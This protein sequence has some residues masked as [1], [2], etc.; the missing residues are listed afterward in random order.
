MSE[1]TLKFET[2]L[3]G[4]EVPQQEASQLIE[5][6]IKQFRKCKAPETPSN[7]PTACMLNGRKDREYLALPR[8]QN[9]KCILFYL[10]SAHLLRR[11]SP[12]AAANYFSLRA[13]W[14]DYDICL[15]D[16]SMEWCV[17]VT[18]NNDVSVI[19]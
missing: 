2:P 5:R 1:S 13:P 4:D 9:R 8:F 15:F 6:F 18:H 3:P 16:E 11:T 19:D 14:E 17:G 12:A 10:E 7:I